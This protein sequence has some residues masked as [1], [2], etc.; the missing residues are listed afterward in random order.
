M[1]PLFI[2]ETSNKSVGLYRLPKPTATGDCPGAVHI[3]QT[4]TFMPQKPSTPSQKP[5]CMVDGLCLAQLRKSH[6]VWVYVFTRAD[7]SRTSWTASV[8][9]S[10]F[11]HPAN[12]PRL[13]LPFSFTQ[14][15]LST[16]TLPKTCSPAHLDE[17]REG[18]RSTITI[19]QCQEL[20]WTQLRPGC[21]GEPGQNKK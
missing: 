4:F 2:K 16:S 12:C 11:S 14:Q 18:W 7:T 6:P 10:A 9:N 13:P 20:D 21:H 3:L 17:N 19:Q 8:K 15:S 1:I 5:I